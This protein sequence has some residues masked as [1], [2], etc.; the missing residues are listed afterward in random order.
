MELWQPLAY[1]ES[2]DSFLNFT[3]FW[4]KT[5]RQSVM[6]VSL[7]MIQ[8]KERLFKKRK[9]CARK[10]TGSS[11]RCSFREEKIMLPVPGLRR[12]VV[13][14]KKYPRQL[15]VNVDRYEALGIR[16]DTYR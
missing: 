15:G 16:M 4:R 10:E 9:D 2:T 1:C 3:G 14:W 13:W 11:L 8:R 7:S 5:G 12:P 6:K